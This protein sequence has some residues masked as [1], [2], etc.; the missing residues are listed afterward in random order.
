MIPVPLLTKE[1]EPPFFNT[2]CREP[3]GAFL[4]AYPE[5]DPHEKSEWWS[6]FKPDLAKHFSHRC[7]WLGTSI[8]LTGAVDHYHG[9][10]NRRGKPSQHRDRAFEW[11]NYRYASGTINS[12]KN[13]HDDKILDPCEIEDDW[14]EVILPNFTLR[15]TDAVPE[16]LREKAKFTIKTLQ[17]FNHEARWTRYDWYRRYWENRCLASLERDA[18]LVAVAVKKAIDAGD[19]LPDPTDCLQEH[20]IRER[21]LPYVKRN[22]KPVTSPDGVPPAPP[23]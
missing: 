14:F 8:G 21:K 9:C 1:N 23:C 4:V 3:G 18:P 20:E 17:L 6:Q 11:T 12:L 22:K 15:F 7:G 5:K 16:N 19:P 13:N 10:G 2:N